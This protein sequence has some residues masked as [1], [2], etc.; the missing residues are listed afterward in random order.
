MNCLLWFFSCE[1]NIPFSESEIN[2]R[3]TN[4]RRKKEGGN[5]GGGV[6]FVGGGG[7]ESRPGLLA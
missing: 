7:G 3:E 2:A 5:F 6:V 4:R 1:R